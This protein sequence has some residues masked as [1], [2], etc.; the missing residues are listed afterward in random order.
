MSTIKQDVSSTTENFYVS[1]YNSIVDISE[2]AED[3]E[4]AAGAGVANNGITNANAP[5]FSDI[6]YNINSTGSTAFRRQRFTGAG[7]FFPTVLVPSI[8]GIAS[9]KC[10]ATIVGKYKIQAQAFSGSTN[11]NFPHVL[12]IR[13]GLYD[14]DRTVTVFTE[15]ITISNFTLNGTRNTANYYATTYA[16]GGS[17]LPTYTFNVRGSATQDG[18][19]NQLDNLAMWV[20]AEKPST[21]V[22]NEVG[23]RGTTL[24]WQPI[25]NSSG[26]N[27][28]KPFFEGTITRVYEGNKYIIDGLDGDIKPS[29]ISSFSISISAARI[30]NIV[31]QSTL[32]ST[33]T[34]QEQSASV[35][36]GVEKTL[37]SNFSLS[38]NANVKHN[39]IASLSQTIELLGTIANFRFA[40]AVL[41][42]Q[43]TLTGSAGIIK[44]LASALTMPTAFTSAFTSN[45]IYDIANDYIW[46]DFS[47]VGYFISGYTARG[48]AADS[49]EYTWEELAADPWE[50]WTYSTWQGP[51]TGWDQWP[52]DTWDSGKKLTSQFITTQDADIV[53]DSVSQFLSQFFVTENAALAKAAE[54]NI[55]AS[56]AVS[57][58]AVG[59]TFG[60]CEITSESS[61]NLVGSVKF[62]ASATIASA[63][64]FSLATSLITNITVT[65]NSAFSLSATQTVKRIGS[66]S[67]ST[68]VALTAAG[69]RIYRVPL[70]ITSAMAF[71]VEVRMVTQAD[72]YFTL[73]VSQEIRTQLVP[74]DLRVYMIDQEK[75][76][77]TTAT[78]SRVLL[79][80]QENR[81]YYLPIPPLTNIKTTP[82]RRS[83]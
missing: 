61:V 21:S 81:I 47:I 34:L 76:V 1:S 54:C 77:N 57:A 4:P 55:T 15:N 74:A 67:I 59:I 23:F 27:L 22:P 37:Q 83:I 8:T 9:T 41:S 31:G 50:S 60:Q 14:N 75:R 56:F 70:I 6:F 28:D 53:C 45:M 17:N 35:I 20:D 69:V 7:A 52:E 39:A 79:V 19:L 66:A 25:S 72:P 73:K 42:A 71:A 33:F 40:E 68:T 63:L 65:K 44:N 46:D 43:H 49:A 38:V 29:I 62:S 13:I 51:E 12:P 36:T 11:F 2:T 32:V 24:I 78:E 30:A 48:Y 80:E 26:V 3:L 58:Q 82:Y 10:R 16:N 64:S 5:R 18:S